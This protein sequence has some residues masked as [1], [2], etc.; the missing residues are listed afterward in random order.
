M[1]IFYVHKEYQRQSIANK[2][3]DA[4]EAEAK[5]QGKTE[6]TSDVSKTVSVCRKPDGHPGYTLDFIASK[7]GFKDARQ[8][9]RICKNIMGSVLRDLREFQNS[10]VRP[11]Q[12][13]RKIFISSCPCRPPAQ[14]CT[15]LPAGERPA[16]GTP[17]LSAGRLKNLQ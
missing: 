13:I 15:C 8:L 9:R 12:V 5:K 1:L 17:F 3:H 14:V 4:L 11:F 16:G 2:L 7:C 6:L 10:E